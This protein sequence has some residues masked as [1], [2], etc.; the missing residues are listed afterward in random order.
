[1]G[2]EQ[3]KKVQRQQLFKVALRKTETGQV[4]SPPYVSLHSPP[5]PQLL[6]P[7]PTTS[8]FNPAAAQRCH[9]QSECGNTP[10]IL[11]M[12]RYL[13]SRDPTEQPA[14]TL[15]S[16]QTRPSGAGGFCEVGGG[17]RC[18]CPLLPPYAPTHTH[19]KGLVW[20]GEKKEEESVRAASADNNNAH[21]W[22]GG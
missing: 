11:R 2:I 20:Q 3:K 19:K 17:Q 13:H 16:K 22:G 1:M 15:A 21:S 9:L 4:I 6:T 5:P 12:A 10:L 7:P 14:D 18:T 8:P